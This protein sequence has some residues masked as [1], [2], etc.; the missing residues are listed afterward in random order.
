MADRFFLVNQFP[1]KFEQEWNF[2]ADTYQRMVAGGVKPY[3]YA[4]FD[5][6]FV[7]NT[8][9]KTEALGA[10]LTETYEATVTGISEREGLWELTADLPRFPVTEDHLI[11]WAID[12]LLKGYEFDCKLDGYGTFANADNN[13]FPDEDGSRLPWYFEEALTAYNKGIY[14]KAIFYFTSAIRIF[15]ENANAWYSRGTVKDV[16]YMHAK[17]R[18]DYDK[19]IELSPAFVEAHINRGVSHDSSGEYEAALA[20]FAAAIMLDGNNGTAYL[21]LGNTRQRMGDI[22]GACT[23]WRKALELGQPQAG[24]LLKKHCE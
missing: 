19:A 15:P 11:C 4:A 21:N 13:E 2:A 5:V 6:Y 16:L 7:S 1:A 23:N 24:E 10:Y 18:E 17:A 3:V 20:D 8:K 22:A 14:S 12:L 9:E